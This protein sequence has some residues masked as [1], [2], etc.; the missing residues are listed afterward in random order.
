MIIADSG[1]TKTHWKL[2]D[3]KSVIAEFSTQG[4][5]PYYCNPDTYKI[6]LMHSFPTE[7]NANEVG[8]VYFYGAGCSSLE[9]ADM[10]KTGLN[11]FFQNAI[12]AVSTDVLAAAHAL[13]GKD[14]GIVIILGS[15]SN[16]G[17]YNGERL[18]H[19]TPSLGYALGD[20]GSGAYLGKELIRSWQYNELPKEL[21]LQLQQ[22]YPF[23]ISQILKKIYFEPFPSRFLASFIP[24]IERNSDHQFINKLVD[25]AFE[26]FIHHH[27]LKYENFRHLPI[28]VVGSVGA[29]FQRNLV[30]IIEKHGGH[31]L[32]IVRYPIDELVNYHLENT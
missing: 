25:N 29:I 5:N 12:L 6:A 11:H 30:Q 10:V 8:K 28:G 4:L 22:E 17:Y 32:R 1:S 21:S 16:V 23:S 13:F 20:E 15:G 27:L 2:L 24:F 7:Y 3:N 19:K 31:L 18:E 26:I 9:M 14:E